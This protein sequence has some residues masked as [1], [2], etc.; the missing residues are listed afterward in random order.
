MLLS[1]VFTTVIVISKTWSPLHGGHINVDSLVRVSLREPT[2]SLAVC[3]HIFFFFFFFLRVVI[4]ETA[5]AKSTFF[6]L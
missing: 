2:R 5:K 6:F 1:S 3:R 4:D